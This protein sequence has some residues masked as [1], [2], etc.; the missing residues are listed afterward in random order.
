MYF[1]SKNKEEKNMESARSS[2]HLLEQ[3]TLTSFLRISEVEYLSAQNLSRFDSL[4]FF[5][6]PQLVFVDPC[7]SSIL[8]SYSLRQYSSEIKVH[9]VNYR[10][11]PS[12]FKFMTY[13]IR[14]FELLSSLVSPREQP[15]YFASWIRRDNVSYNFESIEFSI[16]AHARRK[17]MK[18]SSSSR[19]KR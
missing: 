11:F 19:C 6:V 4:F 3:W 9:I 7:S 15:R 8:V 2:V 13:S 1:S 14:G 12:S 10:L 18:Y 17:I 5:S 16:F